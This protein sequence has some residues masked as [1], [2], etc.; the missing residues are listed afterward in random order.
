MDGYEIVQVA[1]LDGEVLGHAIWRRDTLKLEDTNIYKPGD[2][3]IQDRVTDLNEDFRLRPFWPDT[4]DPDVQKL[5]NDPMWEPLKRDDEGM[6]VD[7][8]AY[9]ERFNL[10]IRLVASQRAEAAELKS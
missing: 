6:A 8:R 2:D 3:K 1:T 4:R 10:A 9:M 7:P 5:I